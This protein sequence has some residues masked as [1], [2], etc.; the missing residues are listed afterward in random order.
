[1]TIFRSVAV[2]GLLSIVAAPAFAASA[3]QVEGQISASQRAAAASQKRVDGLD[4]QTR[5]ALQEYRGALLRAEQLRLY[6]QQLEQQVETQ[7]ARLDE[8][9]E[10]LGR[11]EESRA[12]MVPLLVRM[13]DALDQFV[14]ADQPFDLEARQERVARLRKLLADPEVGLAEQYRA[15]YGAWEAEAQ[16]GRLLKAERVNLPGAPRSQLVDLLQVGRLALYAISLDATAVWQW[17]AETQR[18]E[19]LPATS[20]PAL[21][22]AL[23]VAQE[24]ASPSLLN[25]PGKFPVTQ[26]A[27]A[28]GDQ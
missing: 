23:R 9:E 27:L 15:V 11:V 3:E 8:I 26:A 13:T 16:T 24:Q 20:L 6:K 12:A 19:S 4:D 1:M 10:S 17:N 7:Q 18:F 14:S 2:L 21:K 22:Q 28:G 25:L 5:K